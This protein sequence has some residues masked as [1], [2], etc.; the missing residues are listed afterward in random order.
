[1]SPREGGEDTLKRAT[2]PGT[3]ASNAS[4]SLPFPSSTGDTSDHGGSGRLPCRAS[5]R[6]RGSPGAGGAGGATWL[7]KSAA[8]DVAAR[9]EAQFMLN[10]ASNES[11]EPDLRGA[12]SKYLLHY[13]QVSLLVPLT[14]PTSKLNFSTCSPAGK[15]A[16]FRSHWRVRAE[17]EA[18]IS[19]GMSLAFGCKYNPTVPENARPCDSEL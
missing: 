1:M 6:E 14:F 12:T 7:S 11:L 18:L 19:R 5:L 3:H 4:R 8:E 15:T 13:V 9:E 17:G 10:I 16:D 2:P